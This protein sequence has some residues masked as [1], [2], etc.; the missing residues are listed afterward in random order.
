M[1]IG[2]AQETL[3]EKLDVTFQQVQKYE[4]G[5]NR[6]SASK[7]YQAAK[8]LG[9]PIDYFFAG[10]NDEAEAEASVATMKD[11]WDGESL[12]LN[13][14]FAKIKNRRLA[15]GLL[16]VIGELAKPIAP[17]ATGSGKKKRR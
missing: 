7:L 5:F 16:S 12:A 1:T 9:V 11:V 14:A 15:Q 13:R 6:L 8:L 2:M 17:P 4:S 3:G 10:M